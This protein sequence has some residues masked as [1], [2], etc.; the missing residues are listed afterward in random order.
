MP[1]LGS[2]K[3]AFIPVHRPNADPPDAPVPPDWHND[4]LRRALFDWN[5]AA[6]RSLRAF[7]HTVSSGRADLDAVVLPMQIIDQQDVPPNALEDQF[8]EQLRDQGVDAAALVMLGGPGAGTAECLGCFW[9]RFAMVEQVGV[10]AMELMHTRLAGFDDLYSF[11]GNMDGFDNMAGAGGTHPS[12]YTKAAVEWLD[13]SVIVQQ[14]GLAAT[15]DLHAVGLTQPPP[16][17]RWAAVRVGAEV[18]YLMVE[19][20]LRNDQFDVNIPNPGV[21]VYRAQTS[22]PHGTAQNGIAPVQALTVDSN[23]PQCPQCPVA[24]QPG[25]SFTADGGVTVRV[26]GETVGG[27]TVRVEDP[28]HHVVDRSGQ[29]QTPAA[30]GRPT[31]FVIPGLGVHDIAYRDTSGRLH[32]LWRD[33]QGAT[34]TTNLTTSAG[35]PAA[36]G[37]PFAYVDTARNTVILLFRGGDGTVRSLYWSTGSVGHD[38]LSGTAG[39]PKA[40]GDPVGYY[41]PATDTHHIV[42]R[43]GDGH[44]HELDCVGVAPIIYGGNLTAAI[45]APKAAGQPSG[46]VG[47][48]GV[49]IVAYRGVNNHILGL[50]W[51]DGPS[52]LDDLSGFA[53]TPPTVGDPFAYYTAH[54]DTTQIVYLG[55]DGHVWELYSPGTAPVAGWDLTA[56]SGA[57]KP[58][59][60]LAAYYSAG[61]NT[62]HVIYRSSNG[63]LHVIWWTPGGGTP[64]WNNLTTAYGSPP[65]AD[66]PAAFTVEGPNTQHVAY[67]SNDNHVY[68][69]LW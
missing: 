27:Y 4:I 30:A 26:L 52:G 44:L 38:N 19:A 5:G 60:A 24:L 35:A 43:S 37:N 10:W 28:S 50:Y 63:Q 36:A 45:S 56:P 11:G 6:D 33:T 59:G 3:I 61:T 49:N 54:D 14:S 58:A 32:E 8:G 46:F 67:R 1:W 12:A 40:A 34:G 62:K 41:A 23:N 42:Y 13:A 51:S 21:I 64:A 20:R 66:A 9:A 55:A 69:V 39:A 48:G 68:E 7:I 25:Q 22:D 16:A 57:P 47:S 18:P 15:Y 31:T 53:G 65:A 2:K 29:Y 17:G